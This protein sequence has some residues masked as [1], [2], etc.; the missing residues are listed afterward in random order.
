MILLQSKE[1]K[2]L[3]ERMMDESKEKIKNAVERENESIRKLQNSIEMLKI[4]H[5]TEMEKALKNASVVLNSRVEEVETVAK[6][7]REDD[8]KAVSTFENLRLANYLTN[9][10]LISMG[11]IFRSDRLK[12]N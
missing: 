4:E 7:R 5:K 11:I 10:T 12:L 9:N 3:T 1:K 6:R 8:K 2:I